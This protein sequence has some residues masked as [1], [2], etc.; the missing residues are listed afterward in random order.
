MS[1]QGWIGVDLDGTLAHYDGWKGANHIGEPIPAMV[2][3]VKRWLAEG[4][5]VKIMTARVYCPPA[6]T[7]P[8]TGVNANGEAN[9]HLW[10]EFHKR[11]HDSEMSEKLIRTWCWNV[12]ATTLEVTCTKDYAMIELW[13]DRAVRVVINT[14]NPC[15]K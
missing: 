2:E 15:C 6:P 5:T 9:Y 8:T 11:K 7:H 4:K 14:G 12:F 10:Q 13:D 1:T 3:R